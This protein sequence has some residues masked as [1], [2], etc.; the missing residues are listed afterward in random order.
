MGALAILIVFCTAQECE[1]ACS[2]GLG[3]SGRL[4]GVMFSCAVAPVGFAI[5]TKTGNKCVLRL[6]TCVSISLLMLHANRVDGVVYPH[7]SSAS[8]VPSLPGL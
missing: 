8:S 5:R 4:T 1:S 6:N 3:Y 7:L 2:S